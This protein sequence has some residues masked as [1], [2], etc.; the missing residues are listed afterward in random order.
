[1]FF[2]SNFSAVQKERDRLGRQHSNN[3]KMATIKPHGYIEGDLD[4]DDDDDDLSIL[5]LLKAE[6]T[7]KEV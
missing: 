6:K 1:M 7:A 2:I 3:Y 4:E 5:A